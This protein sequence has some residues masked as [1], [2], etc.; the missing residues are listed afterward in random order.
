MLKGLELSK[1]DEKWYFHHKESKKLGYL[2]PDPS[3]EI[4]LDGMES[5][6]ETEKSDDKYDTD[7]VRLIN[8]HRETELI[9]VGIDINKRFHGLSPKAEKFHQIGSNLNSSKEDMQ[10]LNSKSQIKINKTIAKGWKPMSSILKGLNTEL[11][12]TTIVKHNKKWAEYLKEKQ[13]DKSNNQSFGFG[14]PGFNTEILNLMQNKDNLAYEL[15]KR[16]NML[17]GHEKD[18]ANDRMAD[19]KMIEGTWKDFFVK[20]A[21]DLRNEDHIKNATTVGCN[22]DKNIYFLKKKVP[23]PDLLD[24]FRDKRTP[25]W[26][27]ELDYNIQERRKKYDGIKEYI[28]EQTEICHDKGEHF[29]DI[30]CQNIY[31]SVAEPKKAY[32]LLKCD[33]KSK[34]TFPSGFIL[35]YNESE[36]DDSK[37]ALDIS[38]MSNSRYSRRKIAMGQKDS[39]S[40]ISK[41]TQQQKFLNLG[42]SFHRKSSMNLKT[43]SKMNI[44]KKNKSGEFKNILDMTSGSHLFNQNLNQSGLSD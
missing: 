31:A 12:R 13:Q 19:V 8:G 16:E 7:G 15:G 23:K 32:S 44:I 34:T 11:G 25:L 5:P 22:K 24:M 29:S 42:K 37:E 39:P 9:N 40:R 36:H 27:I 1:E 33:V 17:K 20:E 10:F 21:R 30:V 26:K 41:V 14:M 43:K 35:T 38:R 2:E 6:S 4:N 28:K 3:V 18:K